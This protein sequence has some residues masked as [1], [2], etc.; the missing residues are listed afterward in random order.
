MGVLVSASS[1]HLSSFTKHSNFTN[2]YIE[3][4]MAN[5][6]VESMDGSQIESA[7]T[8]AIYHLLL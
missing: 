6:S 3:C 7:T 8:G 2:R 4:F 1:T 5:P